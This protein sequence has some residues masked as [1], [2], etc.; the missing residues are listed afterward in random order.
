MQH[1]RNVGCIKGLCNMIKAAI[2]KRL[3]YSVAA[4]LL[5]MLALTMGLPEPAFA[6]DGS[7][8]SNAAGNWSDTGK[9]AGGTIADGAG[10]TAWFTNDIVTVAKIITLDGAVA[11]R[12]LGVLNVG[13]SVTPYLAFNFAATGGGTLTFNNSGSPAQ[14][15]QRVNAVAQ[16]FGVP[17]VLAGPLNVNNASANLLSITNGITGSG[18]LTLAANAAGGIT[19]STVVVNPSGTLTNSGPG[20]GTTTISAA[21]GANVSRV[22]QNS[23]SSQLSLGGANSFTGGLFVKSGTVKGTVANAFGADTNRITIGDGSGSADATLWGAFVGNYANPISIASGN[24]GV[25]MISNNANSSYSGPIILNSHDLALAYNFSAT[26]FAFRGDITGTGNLILFPNGAIS[27]TNVNIAGTIVNSGVSTPSA[28]I[29]GTVGSNVTAIIENSASSPMYVSGALMVNSN[30]TSLINSNGALL[31]LS[32]NVWGAG[33]LTIYNNGSL[34]NG[35]KLSGNTINNTGVI[36][37]SGTG[38]GGAMISAN[39]SNKVSRVVQN[40]TNSMLT[41]SGANTFTNGLIIRAGTV[42]AILSVNALGANTNLVTIG[43]I[44]GANDATLVLY[45]YS[46]FAQPITIASNNTGIA[47][48]RAENQLGVSGAVTLQ[49]HD[50]TLATFYTTTPASMSVSGGISGSGN[51]ALNITTNGSGITLSAVAVN[52]S[53]TITNLGAGSAAAVISGG[54]GSNVTAI[55]QASASSALTIDTAPILVNSAGTTLAN[56]SAGDAKLTA[57]YVGGTGNLVLKNNTAIDGGISLLTQNITNM[58]WVV[59]SGSGSGSTLITAVIGSN[60]TR[61]IQ[62]SATS[63]LVLSGANTYGGVTAI[64]NGTLQA[65][66]ATGSATGTGAVN[67]N[68]GGTL[69]GDGT[70]SGTVTNYDGGTISPGNDGTV[71][72]VLTVGSLVWNGGG[73]I[74]VEIDN[75]SDDA[76]RLGH[77]DRLLVNNTM[78]AV[79]GVGKLIIRM[80]SL[81]QTLAFDTNRNYSLKVITCGAAANLTPSDVTLDT[82]LFLLSASGTWTVTNLNKS[83]WVTYRSSAQV[84]NNYWIGSGNWSAATNWSLGHAPLAG[85]AVEFDGR[86]VSNCAANDVSNNLKSITLAA[87]YTGMVTF[88]KNA[89]E[90]GMNLTLSGDLSLREG[91][92]MLACDTNA[93]GGGTAGNPFG[94]GYTVMV[95]NVTLDS[96]TSIRSDNQGFDAKAGPGKSMVNTAGASHGGRGG[97]AYL[98]SY[99]LVPP[100][101]YGSAVGPTSL[102]SGGSG[103]S[104]GGAIKLIVPG[105]A[106]INGILSAGAQYVAQNVSMGSGGSI[107][108]TGGGTLQGTG[109]ITVSAETGKNIICGGGGGRIDIS[110]IVNNFTGSLLASSAAANVYTLGLSGSIRLPQSQGTGMTMDQFVLTNTLT[111]GNS[112]TFTNPVVV[113]NGGLLVLVANTNENIFTFSSLTIASNSSVV[114]QGNWAVAN[115]EAGGTDNNRYGLG[116]T[117]FASNVTILAGGALLAEGAFYAG[118][119]GYATNNAASYATNLPGGY[120]GMAADGLGYTYGAVSNVTA[121]GSGGKGGF[122]GGSL[123]LIV[124]DTLTV[125]GTSSANGAAGVVNCSSGSGGALWLECNR[126]QGAGVISAN[127]GPVSISGAGNYGGGGGRIHLAYAALG[128]PNPVSGGTVTAYG[129]VGSSPLGQRGKGAAG[130]VL[131]TDRGAGESVGTLIIANDMVCSNTVTL[132]PTNSD[133]YAGSPL[134]LTVDKLVLRESGILKVPAN[135]VLAV[136]SAFSNG[137]TFLADSNSTVALVGTNAA[138]VYGSSQFYNF[139]CT[140]TDKLVQFAANSTN[141]ISGTL[142]L[143]NCTLNSTVPGT[144]WYLNLSSN[145]PAAQSVAG[146]NVQDSNAGGGQEIIAR[147]GLVLS[148]D[149]GNNLHWLFIKAPGTF[150]LVK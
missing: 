19:L 125:D 103:H 132:L 74:K 96:G 7:W 94:V 109:V 6:S 139:S 111:F 82:N 70:I 42:K 101:C 95:P 38:S 39:I 81:G 9:W 117:I 110:G 140:N 50:L 25:A 85:E 64:D 29:Y 143:K 11:S 99:A 53:G 27:V 66:N 40:S 26:A 102:G 71:G 80:D 135:R 63:W 49:N 17:V 123:R 76:S 114:C 134:T 10:F 133:G 147:S 136:V 36:T 58:G 22:V 21:I 54:V 89:V 126:L 121:L 90:G 108:I 141:S 31:T 112:L 1:G 34:V 149:S 124:T 62:S 87:G 150:L 128:S 60:V 14:F 43:D 144:W 57:E 41:L 37:N 51:L 68:N 3:R 73:V 86:S 131:L 15:N 35:I 120:G 59:N 16:L 137:A 52:H 88:A 107:W 44:A 46:T 61:V 20:T 113:T 84:G 100:P 72:G 116:V 97:G 104:G 105:V 28:Y 119:P 83:I 24:L 138:F 30:G 91:T 69:A 142:T 127:G 55:T 145:A 93:I 146:V 106:T 130:T 79:P 77:Y 65:S 45:L 115:T 23:A 12:T 92:L 148:K 56:I 67:V 98:C 2:C 78:T 8:T 75:I 118:G 122:G 48:I 13:D 129:G 18:N 33:N 32:G 5:A 4:G 47:T